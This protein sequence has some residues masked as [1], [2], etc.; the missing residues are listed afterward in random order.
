[1]GITA[2]TGG[3]T[4]GRQS[5]VGDTFFSR[6]AKPIGLQLYALGDT[7]GHDLPGTLRAIKQMGYDVVELPNLYGRPATE[8]RLLTQDA[9]LEIASLH[10]P[11]RPMGPGGISFE[12]E[13]DEVARIADALGAN[14]L[15][16]PVPL[17][18]DDFAFREGENFPAAIGRTFRTTGTDHWHRTAHRFNEIGS[19]MTARGLALGFHNHNMEFAPVA[20]TTPFEILVNETD[21]ELVGFQLDIGWVVSAGE[22]PLAWIERLDGRLLSLH[23]KDVAEG[24]QP[25]YYFDT[26][27]TE[28]GSGTI[29]WASVL[30]SAEAAGNEYYFVEQEPPFTMPR[31]EAMAKSAQYLKSLIA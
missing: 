14:H 25:A 22:D 9:G 26:S 1:M 13:P 31:P 28:I 19:A 8:L 23:V 30:P 24:H 11:A 16:M 15:V 5:T 2:L 10:V 12:D 27:P 17:L 21:P 6:I 3:C 20:D 7:V 29:D 18:P 4:Q